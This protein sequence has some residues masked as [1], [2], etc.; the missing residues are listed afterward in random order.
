M[1]FKMF[2]KNILLDTRK[3]KKISY[4]FNIFF[5]PFDAVDIIIN[6]Y[7]HDMCTNI[8]LFINQ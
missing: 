2:S 7:L 4:I 1:L 5:E 6:Q 8:Y 3:R